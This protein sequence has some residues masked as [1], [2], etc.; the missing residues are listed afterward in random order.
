MRDWESGRT[1]PTY[2]Q[3]EDLAGRLKVPIAV[4]FFPAPPNV[5]PIEE[6]FR[7][8]GSEQFARLPPRI[9]ILLRKARALQMGL[10]ELHEG[11]SFSR[12]LITRDLAPG[13]FGSVAEVAPRAREY[14]GIS[15]ETQLEWHSATDAFKVWRKALFH[16][17]VYV[18]KDQFR[19]EGFSGFSLYHE[20][21]PIIYVNNS[22]AVT[23]QIF[24][25][26]HELA[27][28]LLHTSGIE[29]SQEEMRPVEEYRR[30]E[31]AVN[32]FASSLLVPDSVFTEALGERSPDKATAAE[33]ANR[34]KV[35]REFVYRRFLDSNLIGSTA[36]KRQA[37]TWNEQRGKGTGGNYYANQIA[38]LGQHYVRQ[39]FSRYYQN[40]IDA[41]QLA[42]YLDIKPASLERLEQE[43]LRRDLRP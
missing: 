26:F 42:D 18:F 30:T 31:A 24:T 35:S 17:G 14:L 6:S 3:L 19:Q 32:R 9:R 8:T 12:R 20:E 21:F 5:P 4:F 29:S 13:S 23:R 25:L 2:V 41:V 11:R 38:Y 43:V 34:F 15:V 33:L 1:G 40:K 36:Y 10:E 39:A 16:A 28:L 7:T 22:T 37:K 27:H